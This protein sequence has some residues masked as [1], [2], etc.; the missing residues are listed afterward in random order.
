MARNSGAGD[1]HALAGAYALDALD[2]LERATFARHAAECEVCALE[3]AELQETVG[4]M[5]QSNWSVP[6]PRLRAAVLAEAAR[7]RQVG[8]RR[9]DDGPGTGAAARWR[10]RTA[11]AV[12]AGI[13]AAGGGVATWAL[14]Q[15]QVRD[16]H[17][18][19]VAEQERSRRI[20]EVLSAPDARLTRQGNVTVVMSASR[21]TGVVVLDD[22][23][24]P[25]PTQ[26]YELWAGRGGQMSKVGLLGPGERAG[27]VL[28]TD[29]AGAD[30]LGVSKEPAGGSQR[31]TEGSIVAL[32]T[33][34]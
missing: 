29:M 9:S 7:T 22:L 10:R 25:G 15:Q 20:S 31:P 13:L 28:V 26:A 21:D 4:R 1:I 34:A 14:T 11:M 8:N 5:A 27:T 17:A 30:T 24:D 2:D 19:V 18:R 12:A 23:S 6:P 16:E 3:V 32:V 33:L